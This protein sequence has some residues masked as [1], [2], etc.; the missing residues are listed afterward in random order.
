MLTLLHELPENHLVVWGV[1]FAGA[2]LLVMLV[3][4]LAKEDV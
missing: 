1:T 3:A 4:V 2:L